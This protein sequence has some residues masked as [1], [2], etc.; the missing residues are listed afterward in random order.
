[1]RCAPSRLRYEMD[2]LRA[3]DWVEDEAR[4]WASPA[5]AQT[6]CLRTRGIVEDGQGLQIWEEEGIGSTTTS[7]SNIPPNSPHRINSTHQPHN[8]C[9]TPTL[10]RSTL[11]R[12]PSTLRLSTALP[13]IRPRPSFT[14]RRI[15]PQLVPIH[16]ISNS[17]SMINSSSISSGYRRKNNL[18]TLAC[19]IASDVAT[20]I[21]CIISH[22]SR[23]SET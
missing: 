10:R 3:A 12:R 2:S 22:A 8:P 20:S 16:T 1:M 11:R 18:D 14:P 5:T 19:R 7:S 6:V 23:A 13:S 4:A 21:D 17:S 9:T 15:T